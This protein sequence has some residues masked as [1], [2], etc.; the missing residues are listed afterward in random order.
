MGWKLA[1]A[2]SGPDWFKLSDKARLILLR[3]ALAATDEEAEYWAGF[4]PIMAMLIGHE[5]NPGTA[6]FEAARKRVQRY[7]SELVQAGALE[8]LGHSNG[9]H[10]NRYRLLLDNSSMGHPRC[11][12]E[13]VDNSAPTLWITDPET[14]P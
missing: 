7:V 13:T 4:R 10:R 6:E 12:I 14:D 3:M 9:R 1:L 11:P 2:A 5:P 8:K